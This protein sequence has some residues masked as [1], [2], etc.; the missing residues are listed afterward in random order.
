[1][2]DKQEPKVV[3]VD[4]KKPRDENGNVV[5]HSSHS[6]LAQLDKQRLYDEAL[7]QVLERAK[8]LDW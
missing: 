8:S 3:A 5:V 2:T 6:K 1:M 7:A 4:F